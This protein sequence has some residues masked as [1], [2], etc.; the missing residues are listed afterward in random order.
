MVSAGDGKWKFLAGFDRCN[1]ATGVDNFVSG[2]GYRAGFGFGCGE[3]RRG[4]AGGG[5]YGEAERQAGSKG[6]LFISHENSGE[7]RTR[8]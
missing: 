6:V 2:L 3:Q 4:S 1:A 7:R 5:C 8:P